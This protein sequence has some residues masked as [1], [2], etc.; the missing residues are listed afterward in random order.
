MNNH[1]HPPLI[2]RNTEYKTMT[3]N[4]HPHP[5]DAESRHEVIKKP[6]TKTE[7]GSKTTLGEYSKILGLGLGASEAEAKCDTESSQESII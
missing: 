5:G 3:R 7:I 4:H 6:P 2:E 1:S